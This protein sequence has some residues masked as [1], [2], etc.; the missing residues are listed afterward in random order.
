MLTKYEENGLE[1]S[2][3][4]LPNFSSFDSNAIFGR[5]KLES[6]NIEQKSGGFVI[7]KILLTN[8]NDSEAAAKNVTHYQV[9]LPIV[10]EKTKPNLFCT[11]LHV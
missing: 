4:Y 1:R 9:S 5:F 11:F 8:M 7:T 2:A 10:D 3:S 6:T